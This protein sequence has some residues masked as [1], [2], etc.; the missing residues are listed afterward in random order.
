VRS[1]QCSPLPLEPFVRIGAVTDGSDTPIASEVTA[2]DFE[3]IE[4]LTDPQPRRSE[5]SVP[6]SKAPKALAV[7][8]Q[9]GSA[10]TT[11]EADGAGRLQIRDRIKE[12]RRVRAQDL[13][14]NPKN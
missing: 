1:L 7:T 12:L 5:P 10:V 2:Q 8:N 4:A 9:P 13:L 14:P 3:P 11:D 6:L